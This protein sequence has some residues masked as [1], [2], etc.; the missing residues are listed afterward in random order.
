MVY[1]LTMNVVESLSEYCFSL[2]C[3]NLLCAPQNFPTDFQAFFEGLNWLQGR[4]LHIKM[5]FTYTEATHIALPNEKY[6]VQQWLPTESC[7]ASRR[8]QRELL[9]AARIA[10]SSWVKSVCY[11]SCV[12]L[13]LLAQHCGRAVCF[14]YVITICLSHISPQPHKL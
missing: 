2:A 13:R 1:N 12:L 4:D 9:P 3:L 11:Q 6:P 14:F 8:K 10:I 7:R 5:N